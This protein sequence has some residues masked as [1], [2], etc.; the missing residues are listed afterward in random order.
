MFSI[1]LPYILSIPY[2]RKFDKQAEYFSLALSLHCYV[3][4]ALHKSRGGAVMVTVQQLRG[5][6]DSVVVEQER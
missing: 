3:T 6:S 4:L 2:L 1:C 5:I